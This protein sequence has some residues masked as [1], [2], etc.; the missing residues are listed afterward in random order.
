MAAKKKV[1]SPGQTP[2]PVTPPTKPK[3]DLSKHWETPAE[4]I[5]VPGAGYEEKFTSDEIVEEEANKRRA[6]NKLHY[7]VNDPDYK[8]SWREELGALGKDGDRLAHEF[9]NELI[10]PTAN[11]VAGAENWLRASVDWGGQELRQLGS[12]STMAEG[13]REVSTPGDEGCCFSTVRLG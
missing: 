10:K 7:G 8:P 1:S 5:P 3:G 4:T 6:Y 2:P 13:C 11:L 12:V 9:F